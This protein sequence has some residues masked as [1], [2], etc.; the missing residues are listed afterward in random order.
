MN[1]TS[2]LRFLF[3]A[4]SAVLIPGLVSAGT[5]GN[6]LP[7]LPGISSVSLQDTT[8]RKQGIKPGENK[9]EDNKPVVKKPDIK[10]VPKSRR[11]LKP[12]AVKARIKI[13]VKRIK[14]IIKR[15]IGLIR[16]N[17]GI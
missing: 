9:P 3:F 1:C 16:R 11:Q 5:P 6:H 4:L 13:P 2:L 15:P 14:P 17:L 8:G 7:D 10:E 12:V